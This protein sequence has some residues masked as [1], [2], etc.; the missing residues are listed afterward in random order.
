MPRRYSG[1]Y[2]RGVT[3]WVLAG[4]NELSL[5]HFKK[6]VSY[7]LNEISASYTELRQVSAH[8]F[9]SLHSGASDADMSASRGRK[10]SV[11]EKDGMNE[12]DVEGHQPHFDATRKKFRR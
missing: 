7:R 5:Y 12:K 8:S 6:Q 9:T 1:K 4:V 11:D 2:V 10:K 3:G